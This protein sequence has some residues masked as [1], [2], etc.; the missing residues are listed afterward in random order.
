[1]MMNKAHL[2]IVS[3]LII[4]SGIVLVKIALKNRRKLL[5]YLNRIILQ[6]HFNYPKTILGNSIITNILDTS[7]NKNFET[8]EVPTVVLAGNRTKKVA[9][10]PQR[11]VID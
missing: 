11:F 8:V 7:Q 6:C 2:L 9:E 3:P 10:I 1:M 5:Y 4:T